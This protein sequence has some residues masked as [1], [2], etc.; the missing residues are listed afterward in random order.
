MP[1]LY[2]IH[3][4]QRVDL[5][6]DRGLD[7]RSDVLLVNGSAGVTEPLPERLHDLARG[8]AAAADVRRQTGDDLVND[9]LDSLRRRS[10]RHVSLQEL[11]LGEER[12]SVL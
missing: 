2:P 3:L 1:L 4:Q 11:G 7:A 8:S 10:G 5:L 9:S 6:A 12:L